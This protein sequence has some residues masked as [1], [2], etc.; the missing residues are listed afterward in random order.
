MFPAKSSRKASS[1][2][3]SFFVSHGKSVIDAQMD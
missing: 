2:H 1:L 3:N